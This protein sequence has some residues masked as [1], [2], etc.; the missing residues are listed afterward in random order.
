MDDILEQCTYENTP[1]FRISG[2]HRA[3]IVKVY[4]GDTV[5]V[6]IC[7]FGNKPERI[8]CRCYGYNSAEIKSKSPEEKEMGKKSRD[9]LRSLILHKIVEIEIIID[10][11]NKDPYKRPL[12]IIRHEGK[13]INDLMVENG[14][15]KPYFGSGEKPW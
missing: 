14:Y 4:D 2:T 5:T 13:I 6:A 11:K 15:G 10:S 9:Y 8:S 12:V 7:L 1:E 3:K